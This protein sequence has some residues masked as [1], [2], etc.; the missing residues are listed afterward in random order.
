M[1]LRLV[2]F[3]QC[4]KQDKV[5]GFQFKFL[6][7]SKG[8]QMMWFYDN[9]TQDTAAMLISPELVVAIKLLYARSGKPDGFPLKTCLRLFRP[10]SV[11]KG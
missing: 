5:T 3:S 11:V 8:S 6:H 9:V 2:K 10:A 1:S 4:S 7:V